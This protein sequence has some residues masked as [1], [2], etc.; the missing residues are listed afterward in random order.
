MKLKLYTSPFAPSPRRVRMYAAEK[1]VELEYIDVSIADGANRTSAFLEI[2]PFGETPVLERE[3]GQ[4]TTESLAICRWL[5]EHHPEP[6]LFG[7]DAD[8]RLAVNHWID[9]LMFR[10]YVPTVEVFRH[11]HTFW[12]GRLEQVPAF[13]E[14][15][16]ATVHAAWQDLDAALARRAFVARDTFS[17]ADIVAFTT[18]DFAKVIG[19]R[20]DGELPALKLWYDA[21]RARPSSQA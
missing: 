8:E 3:D 1:G 15:Q 11:T 4:R 16:R 7:G 12:A 6:E 10:M 5:E 18:V 20:V 13:G 21:V 19:M 2:N 9:R 14:L 17:M